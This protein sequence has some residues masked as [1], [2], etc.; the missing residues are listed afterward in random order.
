MKTE[1][2]IIFAITTLILVGT[3]PLHAA[4]L[5]TVTAITLDY[6]G[7]ARTTDSDGIADRQSLSLSDVGLG[8]LPETT[9][10]SSSGGGTATATGLAA[11]AAET[12]TG[13]G[14]HT[15]TLA[16]GAR[17]THRSSVA[18]FTPSSGFARA[19]VTLG[20]Q[21]DFSERTTGSDIDFTASLDS[22]G[23]SNTGSLSIESDLDGTLYNQDLADLPASWQVSVSPGAVVTLSVELSSTASQSPGEFAFTTYRD[24]SSQTL[25]LGIDL[26]LPGGIFQDDFETLAGSR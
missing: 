8:D 26:N 12:V 22:S 19:D 18:V 10:S 11:S 9:V 5:F 13:P 7:S 4:D 23:D 3:M 21:I 1:L 24:S 20:G 2:K 15:L 17:A 6:S 16:T 14:R 25:D